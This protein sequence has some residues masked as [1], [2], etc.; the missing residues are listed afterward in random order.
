MMKERRLFRLFSTLPRLTE[1]TDLREGQRMGASGERGNSSHPQRTPGSMSPGYAHVGGDR[2][3]EQYSLMP[4]PKSCSVAENS[5]PL[6]I[7]ASKK[8]YLGAQRLVEPPRTPRRS[9]INAMREAYAARYTR[10]NF[11]LGVLGADAPMSI[12]QRPRR[13]ALKHRGDYSLQG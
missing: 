7:P 8:R 9:A 5:P 11:P 1:F 12:H 13:I 2:Q 3:C 10:G 6:H 4:H